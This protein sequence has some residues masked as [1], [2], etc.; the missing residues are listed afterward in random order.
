MTKQQKLA[1]GVGG[2]FGLC[3]LA[4]GWFLYSA[5]AER[6][7]IEVGGDSVPE[8]LA[9]AKDKYGDFYSKNPFPSTESINLVKAKEKAYEQWKADARATASKGDLPPPPSR[10]DSGDL[11]IMMSEQIARMQKL[12]GNNNGHICAP[13]FQFGFE[14][15]LD[16]EKKNEKPMPTGRKELLDLYAQ[17]VTITNVVDLLYANG[18]N[19]VLEIRR[20]S[21]PKLREDDLADKLANQKKKGGKGKQAKGAAVS[22]G[23]VCYEFDLEYVVRPSAFVKVLNEFAKTP[24]FY[25]VRAM[26]FGH[27]GESLKERLNRTANPSKSKDDQQ[28]GG[29]RGFSRY[30]VQEAQE[31]KVEGDGDLV[32]RPD[33]EKPILVT[34]KLCGYDFLTGGLS[35]KKEDK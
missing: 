9:A 33:I 16:A 30:R 7:E 22:E 21:R 1:A 34:M 5:Y 23:P 27:E 17:F 8:G 13:S 11:K 14:P 19:G 25:V 35:S 15:Y 4:L 26:S 29:R 2:A 10:L 12:P 3:V 28:S 31:Q 20:I 6:R 24:R 32:T 18:T